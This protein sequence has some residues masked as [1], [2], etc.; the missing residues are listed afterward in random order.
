MAAKALY[1]VLEILKNR[2]VFTVI[3][4]PATGNL[5]S[6]RFFIKNGFKFVKHLSDHPEGGNDLY[7][8][9]LFEYFKNF[10]LS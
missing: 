2:N 5:R 4:D 3:T 9:E 7:Q 1:K 10:K 8:C 6:K